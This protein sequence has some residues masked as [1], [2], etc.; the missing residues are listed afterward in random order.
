LDG[1]FHE[2]AGRLAAAAKVGDRRMAG[3]YY[4][5]LADSCMACHAEYARHRFPGYA[6]VGAPAGHTH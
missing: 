4:Y 3:F 5:K 1:E 6:S 2:L